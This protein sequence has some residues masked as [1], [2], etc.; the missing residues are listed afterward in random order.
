MADKNPTLSITIR[1]ID[2]ASAKIREINARLDAATRPARDFKKALSDFGEKSGLSSLVDGFKG[3]GSAIEGLLAKVAVIGGVA[4]LAVRGLF[5]LVDEFDKLGDTAERVGVSVD[6]LSSMR[7]AAEKAGAPVEALDQGLTN[8]NQNIGQLRANTGRLYSFLGKVSPALLKQ[9]QGA[10]DNAEAFDLMAA[11]IAKLPDPARRAAL[12]QK[13][14]GDSSLAPLL[15]KGAAGVK[16]LR[17]RYRELSPDMQE[18]ADKAGA[19]DDSL[20]EL[21]AAEDGVKA[22]LVSG[23]APALKI[24]VDRLRDWLKGHREDLKA[25]ATALGEKLPGAVQALVAW[26]GKA[27]DKVM[28]FVDAIGGWKTVA[29]ALGAVLAGPLIGALAQLSVAVLTNPMLLEIAAITASV[30]ALSDA[31][32]GLF[33]KALPDGFWNDPVGTITAAKNGQTPG[34]RAPLIGRGARAS[35][36]AARPDISSQVQGALAGRSSNETKITVDFT[37]A[38]RGTKATAEG[39]ADVGV[40]VGYM[41]GGF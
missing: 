35:M 23:L 38:P 40:N 11:A 28:G 37:H 17:D 29:I 25:W 22:A 8:F 30:L 4:G 27:Y 7:Y 1:T 26:I 41:L 10:K 14:F 39:D 31:I 3:V 19:V 24:I 5:G 18:A 12:A 16:Q 9:V 21:H 33:D 20:H 15:A 2:A 6:F 32:D 13:A 34:V 36:S